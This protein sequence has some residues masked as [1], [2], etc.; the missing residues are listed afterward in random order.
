MAQFTLSNNAFIASN[1]SIFDVNMIASEDGNVISNTNPLPI[2]LVAGGTVSISGPISVTVGNVGII[3]SNGTPITNAAPLDVKPIANSSVY[4]NGGNI[5][6][7]NYPLTQNVSFSNQSVT[8]A[9]GYISVNNLPGTQNVSFSNQSVTISSGTVS[10]NNLPTTQNV[11]FSNQ[12]ITVSGGTLNVS[13]FT[14]TQNVSFANQSVTVSG[15]IAGITNTV[16]VSV[17][18][19]P[20]T[21][22]VNVTFPTTQNVAFSNQSITVSGGN[23][24][25]GNYPVTQNV[26]FS[27]QSVTISSGTISVNSFPATQNVQVLSNTSNYVYTQFAPTWSLD[28]LSKVRTSTTLNQNWYVP[29]IDDDT[30]F[31]WSQTLA[32]TAANS[33][34]VSNTNEIILQSGLSAIGSVARQTYEK[35]KIIPGTSHT[36]YTTVNFTANTTESGVT[37]RTGMFSNTNGIF[38]EQGG[39]S[40]NTLAVV[41][42]RRQANGNVIEDRTYANAFSV[43][44]LDGTGPSG[45][46]IFSAGLNKYYTFWFD[47]I[48]GRT[49]RIRFGMGTP[50]GPQIC[51]VQSYTG[52]VNTTF[53]TNNSLPLRREIFNSSSQ[54][55]T[56]TFGM[57]GISFQSEAPAVFNPSP[58]TAYNITPYTPNTTLTPILSIGLRSGEPYVFSDISPEQLLLADINNQ[59]KNSSPG[60]FLYVLLYNANVNGIPVYSNTT[61]S[62]NCGR[63]SQYWAWPNTA[64]VSGGLQIF[65]GITQSGTGASSFQALPTTYNLGS[66]INGNPATLTLAVQ[67]VAAGGSAAGLVATWNIIEQL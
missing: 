59:G 53:I 58:T 8:V 48:G 57:S 42:R 30:N 39:V 7:G 15:N 64:T 10:V 63:S 22:N 40:A 55:S 65:S 1:K 47:F 62:A 36:V 14:V 29:V 19:F 37:R 4:V 12:T 3:H 54:T 52:T 35:F 45:F 20:T 18:N 41:V 5:N 31:R 49:G 25:I 60:T 21:Q 67:Q 16:T 38:W 6:I 43:D 34:F 13:N 56:P 32:G 66:D 33:T 28:A 17:N 23:I 27:N 9:N 26:S 51:H 50:L 44:K 46:N 24:N 61:I 2:N 11:S